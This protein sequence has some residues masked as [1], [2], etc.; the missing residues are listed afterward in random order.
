MIEKDRNKNFVI[1]KEL[2]KKN[3]ERNYILT[4]LFLLT[5]RK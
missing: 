3:K 2:Y 4:F 5:L 1:T